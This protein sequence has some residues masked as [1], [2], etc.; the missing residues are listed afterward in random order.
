MKAK[1]NDKIRIISKMNDWSMEYQEGDI[2]TVESTWY[3]GVNVCSKTGVPISLDEV[4]YEVIPGTGEDLSD[5]VEDRKMIFH[6]DSKEGF[7]RT[8]KACG[9][10]AEGWEKEGCPGKIEILAEAEA[11]SCCCH[12][13][14][15]GEEIRFLQGRAVR[16][17]ACG[18]SMKEYGISQE[19]LLENIQI[20]KLGAAL[21]AEKQFCGYAYV[22][23]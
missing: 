19:M 22:K 15:W 14:E 2:F 23:M 20:T 8:L 4:E 18:I 3:G 1:V 6:V 16:F 12:D 7:G 11:L 17:H 5:S 9:L 21:L 13:E 10:L